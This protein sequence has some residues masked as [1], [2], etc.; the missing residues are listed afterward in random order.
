MGHDPESQKKDA[1]S[2]SA[3]QELDN[4]STAD[5]SPVPVGEVDMAEEKVSWNGVCKK[6][7]K[8]YP[9]HLAV[10][11]FSL[12]SERKERKSV[13]LSKDRRD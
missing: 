6:R 10:S 2:R 13:N 1:Y 9:D 3:F 12:A 4:Q 8:I 7:A 11:R 5:N